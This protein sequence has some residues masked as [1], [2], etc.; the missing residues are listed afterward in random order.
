MA[1][2]GKNSR[3]LHNNGHTTRLDGLFD[4]DGNLLGEPFLNLKSSTERLGN[5]C[6]LRQTQNELSRYI[7]DSDLGDKKC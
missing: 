4:S 1:T 7:S 2:D 3:C 5:T 6:E